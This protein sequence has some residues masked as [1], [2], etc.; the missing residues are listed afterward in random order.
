MPNCVTCLNFGD[1][2]MD[3]DICMECYFTKDDNGVR[4]KPNYQTKITIKKNSSGQ[5]VRLSSYFKK[6]IKSD[7]RSLSK[8]ATEYG[9]STTSIWKIKNGITN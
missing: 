1:T 2:C 7:S 9:V 3:S 5:H 6:K 8:I 4:T